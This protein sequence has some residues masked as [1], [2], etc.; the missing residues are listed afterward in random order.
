MKRTLLIT[1]R[2]VGFFSL[3]L[4]AIDNCMT[5]EQEGLL[6]WVEYG[7]EA[8]AYW[9]GEN[10][11]ETFFEQP[12]LATKPDHFDLRSS[13]FGGHPG[14]YGR[15]QLVYRC[16][17]IGPD[18]R[19]RYH[20]AVH[21]YGR[22][23]PF[24][25]DKAD[26]FIA[27]LPPDYVAIHIRGTDRRK[28]S[29]MRPL[30]DYVNRLEAHADMPI[31]VCADSHEAVEVVKRTYREVHAYDAIRSDRYDSHDPV[32][33]PGRHDPYRIAEDV[34]IEMLIMS[35]ARLLIHSG[36]NVSLTSWLWNDTL[37]HDLIA[38]ERRPR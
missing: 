6:A 9:N 15:Q 16:Q 17:D 19:Q 20:A 36:S 35:R 2:K 25:R 4:Q 30:A 8:A 31:V 13:S 5:A 3:F 10:V 23:R 33:V 12:M 34:I 38:L 26:A 1:G 7:R 24:V 29:F 37:E 11:W 27:S 32:H 28:D 22:L 18:A 21:A 14:G